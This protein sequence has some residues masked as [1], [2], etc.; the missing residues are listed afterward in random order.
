[1]EI[2]DNFLPDWYFE[3]LKENVLENEDVKWF[4]VSKNIAGED[5]GYLTDLPKAE[6]NIG[7]SHVFFTYVPPLNKLT[8]EIYPIFEPLLAKIEHSYN[9][10]INMLHRIR[11]V[12]TPS[13]KKEGIHL[14]HTDETSPH[15][16]FL[17][18]L[19]DSDG[20]TIFF[21]EKYPNEEKKLTVHKRIKPKANTAVLFD[22]L[23]LHSSSVPVNTDYRATINI[24]FE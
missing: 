6:T 2:I 17:Y 11:A 4:F 7:F 20:D 5:M 15:Y 19:N 10:K 14:P 3:V 21:N 23:Q 18:Y 12:I 13:S 22:G 1:M 9:I 8:T 16:T 24:N